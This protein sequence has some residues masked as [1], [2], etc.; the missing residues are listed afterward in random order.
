MYS[1]LPFKQEEIIDFGPDVAVC[2]GDCNSVCFPDT[3]V[4]EW[5]QK[6]REDR[7][8]LVIWRK[9]LTTLHYFLLETLIKIKEWTYK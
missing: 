2:D 5:R 9:P 3:A 7:L 8:S 1:E 6:D 4:K